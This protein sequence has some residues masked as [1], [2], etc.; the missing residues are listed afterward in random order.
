MNR[1][2]PPEAPE[3][4]GGF[5]GRWSRLKRERQCKAA[6]AQILPPP[7]ENDPALA[8]QEAR[9]LEERQEREAAE[10]QELLDSL[11]KVDEITASTDITG[12]LNGRIPDVL[13]NAALRAAW[14]ADPAIRDF[15]NDAREYALDYNTPGAAYGYG[16]LTD[17]DRAG[18]GEMVRNIF[19]DA[20]ARVESTEENQ[21]L[22]SDHTD[23]MGEIETARLQSAAADL[24]P[25]EPEPDSPQDGNVE[26]LAV[27]I[28]KNQLEHGVAPVL[29]ARSA[30]VRGRDTLVP[31]P[32]LDATYAAASS[33][34]NSQIRRRSG[35]ALP[36]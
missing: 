12:F 20:P 30:S 22:V 19:G 13:R 6:E 25:L 21:T 8:A 16:P 23:H 3:N 4:E 26:K 31:Q 24:Q 18:L 15:L 33:S 9:K 10:L 17:S 11:P 5:L 7:A 27:K 14:S 36:S 1:N 34:E 29:T 28:E 35:G 32:A 2:E